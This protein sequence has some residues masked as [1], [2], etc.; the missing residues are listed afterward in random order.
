VRRLLALVSSIIFV[1]ALL[2]TALTPLVPSYVEEFDLT[3]TGAGLLVGAYGAGALFG[4]IPGGLAAARWGAKPAVVGA[5]LLLAVASFAFAAADTAP[6]LGAAR[7]VQGIASTATWAG[8]LAWISVEAPR[9]RRGEVIGTTF[10][11][12]VFGSVLG[13]VFGGL[14][15]LAGVGLSF[16]LVGLV[17]LA[18]AGLAG[19][20]RPARPQ[21][22]AFERLATAFRDP[23][24]VGGL[25]LSMLP[26]MLFG[27]LI[28]LAPLD[29]H[30]AGWSTLAIALVF[31]V[32]SLTEV[33]L[34]P[35]LGRFSD[36]VGRLLP[37]RAALYASTVVAVLLA[38]SSRAVVVAA[39]V[40][41]ATLSF[42]S[43]FTPGVS[44]TSHR[45]DAAGLAQG[46]SYGVMNTAWA[47]GE[48]AGPTA[49][50][51]LAQSAGDGAP[52]L[53][54]AVLCALTLA[55]TYRVAGRLRPSEA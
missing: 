28:V 24:F 20:A 40:V 47:F 8:A 50:G 46:L 34:N 18:F 36:R 39:L 31:F 41:A 4:G 52:Y 48:L 26:A 19:L 38:A 27:V 44:L 32:A 1:D 9:E 45:A 2:F 53:V 16:G 55:T 21:A 35:L 54:G 37:I 14:A 51:A 22:L 17:T 23:R 5:L 15:E 42:G 11:V 3:K 12:A 13:P 6:A 7:F 29:L 33:V 49:G 25:W 10:G 43:F 30:E